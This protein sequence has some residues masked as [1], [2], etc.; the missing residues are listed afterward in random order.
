[1]WWIVLCGALVGVTSLLRSPRAGLVAALLLLA[2]AAWT[3]LSV[4]WS[5][6]P[7]RTVNEISRV[8]TYLGVLL[9]GLGAVALGHARQLLGG[10]TFAVALVAALGVLSRLHPEWFPANELGTYLPGIEIERRLAYPFNYSS[11]VGSFAAI[12]LPLVL[13]AGWWARTRLMQCLAAAAIPIVG[14]ALY[15]ATSGTGAI[16]AVVAV[17]SCSPRSRAPAGRRSWARQ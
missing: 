10:V 4:A 14:L 1:V 16:T 13:G 11:A 7:E 5:E 9:L 8:L 3:A 15:L 6:S 12:G 17:G 2:F